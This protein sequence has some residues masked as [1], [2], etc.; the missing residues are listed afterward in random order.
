LS[1]E[2]IQQHV[3]R[4]R[5]KGLDACDSDDEEL[6]NALLAE[7][8]KRREAKTHEV[9][10]TSSQTSPRNTAT[11]TTVSMND[12]TL[13]TTERAVQDS[14]DADASRKQTR[15]TP[16]PDDKIP[17]SRKPTASN[18]LMYRRHPES[19]Q[20]T[21]S[22]DESTQRP[23]FQFANAGQRSKSSQLPNSGYNYDS[24]APSRR[25]D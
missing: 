9:E 11:T 7:F 19:Y 2:Q 4:V 6:V 23:Y 17:I 21:T 20:S 10:S 3:E 1:D 18:N 24:P 14:D 8:I 12:T 15:W 13:N 25:R 16:D 22:R 5:R